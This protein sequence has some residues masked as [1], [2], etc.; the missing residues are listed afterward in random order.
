MYSAEFFLNH[1]VSISA[2][3]FDLIGVSPEYLKSCDCTRLLRHHEDTNGT[4]SVLE[5]L[6]FALDLG[7]Y[8]VAD[9]LVV[10]VSELLGVSLR[11]YHQ[12]RWSSI[13]T[14]G[15][16]GPDEVLPGSRSDMFEIN[17]QVLRYKQLSEIS[18]LGGNLGAICSLT[19]WS[20]AGKILLSVV[21]KRRGRS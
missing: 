1:E 15:I 2:D 16:H 8:V 3:E 17:I 11:L 9:D 14:E 13:L 18:L 4:L 7:R 10:A 21:S 5:F 19:G 12:F 20:L 6:S